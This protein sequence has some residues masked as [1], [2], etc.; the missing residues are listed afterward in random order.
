MTE[1][2]TRNWV[3][4]IEM[5]ALNGHLASVELYGGT[6]LQKVGFC[7]WKGGDNQRKLKLLGRGA[8]TMPEVDGR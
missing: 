1:K 6:G 5:S 7:F 4:G 2:L 8:A 3:G